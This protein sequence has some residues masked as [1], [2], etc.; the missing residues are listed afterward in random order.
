[1]TANLWT[2]WIGDNYTAG[3]WPDS[4]GNGRTATQASASQKPSLVSATLNGHSVA[5]FDGVDD[6]LSAASS[7]G[8]MGVNYSFILVATN[9]SNGGTLLAE[10]ETSS[11]GFALRTNTFE[12][13]GSPQANFTSVSPEV[14]SICGGNVYV[15]GALSAPITSPSIP[16][17][18]GDTYIGSRNYPGY[19]QFLAGDIAEILIYSAALNGTDRSAVEHYLGTKYGITVS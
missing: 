10:D 16:S 18:T 19:Q 8:A 2:R 1:M 4:S 12:I 15:N 3:S 6:T 13:G 7:V 5:R 17:H 9:L 11:R 14:I